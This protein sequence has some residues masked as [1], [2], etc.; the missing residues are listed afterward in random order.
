MK[1]QTK[2][3]LQTSLQTLG[4]IFLIFFAMAFACKDGDDNNSLSP[5]ERRNTTKT[6]GRACSTEEEFKAII[7][8]QKTFLDRDYEKSEVIFNSFEIEGPMHYQNMTE[9]FMTVTDD[10]YRVTTSFDKITRGDEMKTN[11]V[12]RMRFENAVIMFYPYAGSGKEC[13]HFYEKNGLSKDGVE[14]VT[15][16]Y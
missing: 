3:N 6:N 12:Y 13:K 16:E 7:T 4:I 1:K 8:H 15:G 14:D 11:K 2:S 10:A 9:G 5:V